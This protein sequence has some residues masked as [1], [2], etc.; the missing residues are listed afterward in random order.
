MVR[1]AIG[2]VLTTICW[3][4]QA[5]RLIRSR[6]T[7]AISLITNLMFCIGLLFW[8]VYGIALNDW[9]LI[10]SNAISIVLTS[11]II[12]MKLRHG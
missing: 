4:P 9:P 8:L 3:P 1:R 5:V 2:A 7:Q 6:E 10:G 12:A 11:V